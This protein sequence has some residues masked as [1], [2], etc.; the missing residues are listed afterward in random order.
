MQPMNISQTSQVI[1]ETQSSSTI[2]VSQPQE[3]VFMVE[4][5]FFYKAYDDY[6]IYHITCKE[7]L[8][9]EVSRLCSNHDCLTQNHVLPSNLHVFYFQ[10]SDD[11]K[12][13]KVVC[14]LVSYTYIICMLNKIKYGIEQNLNIQ[15]NSC[16]TKQHKEK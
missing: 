11:K 10:Q 14:E 9:E 2:N 1:Q 8:F 3:N 6:Q 13:Y 7:I 12:I 5:S 15:E 16:F 4:Y